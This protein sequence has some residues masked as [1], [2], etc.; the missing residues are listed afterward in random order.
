MSGEQMAQIILDAY[1]TNND[2]KEYFEFFL[3]PD[4][5]K[6]TEKHLSVITRE[7][8]KSKWG[9]SKARTSV[10]KKAVKKYMG[11]NPG[12]EAVLEMLFL[13]L[14]RLGTAERYLNFKAP[15]LNYITFLTKQI[16]Q[17]ADIYC[18]ASEAMKR[19][20]EELNSAAY[21]TYFKRHIEEAIN[22]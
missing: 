18:L 14:N 22:G 7:L 9:Y 11:F 17:H 12:P 13:T 16:L 6:L 5:E 3:N 15:L 19:L 20:N 4:I 21:T 8:N 1:E 10:I 2:V